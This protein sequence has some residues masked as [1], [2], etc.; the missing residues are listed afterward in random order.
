MLMEKPE[1]LNGTLKD[2]ETSETS[3]AFDAWAAQM[4]QRCALVLGA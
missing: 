3:G 4:Q 2:P 1:V